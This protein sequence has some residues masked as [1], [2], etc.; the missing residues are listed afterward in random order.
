MPAPA[1]DK[2]IVSNVAVLKKKYGSAGAGKLQTAINKLITADAARAIVTEFVDLSDATT[3]AK[4]GAT[5]LTVAT[6]ANPKLNKEAIDKVFVKHVPQPS[7]LMLLGSTDVIPHVQLK[8]PMFG[9]PDGD[10][11]PDLPSDLP[12]AS[13]KAYSTDVQKYVA[14][15]RVVGRLP[16][17]TNDSS[18]TYLIGLIESAANYTNRP[19]SKY[20]G[21]LGIT[22]SVWKKSSALSLD[23]IFVDHADMK[24]SPPDGF[25]WTA[26]QAKRLT[27]FINCHGAP[28]DP[29]FY[30]QKGQAYPVAHDAKWM[31]GKVVEGTILAAECCFGA[32]LY[33]PAL[34]TA[35]GQM[36]MCNT[37]L[38]RKAYSFF[39][40]TNTAY[41]PSDANDQADLLCQYFLQ[42][43]HGGASAGRACL[44]ARLDYVALKA[45]QMGPVDFK[46]I[47]QFN[48]MGDPSLTPVAA[49]AP[50]GTPV[51][52]G[53]S[54]KGAKGAD[55]AER[56]ARLQRRAA[57]VEQAATTTAY[58]LVE[59]K[60]TSGTHKTAAFQELRRAAAEFGVKVPGVILSH[61]LV[62]PADGEKSKAFA[63]RAKA[64]GRAPKAVHTLLQRFKSP[65]EVPHLILVKG[66]QA[67]EYDQGM[68]VK[69]FES[70]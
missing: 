18:P 3:M 44:Q 67:I 11:D 70:R 69:P 49:A 29:H 20:A 61:E 15:S 53:A 17:V 5:A 66:V 65:A 12:Y 32:E 46:T 27:H 62:S 14:P 1:P 16:N 48:L 59:R 10:D 42:Q 28:A 43:V 39:G 22:A 33:D 6:A 45:G 54:K 41:G 23:A 31:A 56:Y 37:Y 24:I 68:V 30:G 25:K 13:D 55:V 34:P 64:I 60:V 35:G 19:A 58:R 9:Q 51:P 57:L 8:N 2:V 52:H 36:G 40:S 63:A 7:Y 50:H 4:Y 26:A 21:Y 47:G 38:G